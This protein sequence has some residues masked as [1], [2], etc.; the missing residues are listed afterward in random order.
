MPSSL[1]K[2]TFVD[3]YPA[4]D[5]RANLTEAC[6]ESQVFNPAENSIRVGFATVSHDIGDYPCSVIR[7]VISEKETYLDIVRWLSFRIAQS[8]GTKRSKATHG[9]FL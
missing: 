9:T 2:S 6:L 3:T 7:Y 4:F 1:P 8:S 5:S